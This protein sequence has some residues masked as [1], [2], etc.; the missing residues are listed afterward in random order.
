MKSF[1]DKVLKMAV[2]VLVAAIL[3]RVAWGF[4]EPLVPVLLLGGVLFLLVR[5]VIHRRR[6]W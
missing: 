6:N 4:L 2:T 5:Y 1:T 3:L